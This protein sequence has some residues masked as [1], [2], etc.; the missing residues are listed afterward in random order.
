MTARLA[1]W[2]A[3]GAITHEDLFETVLLPLRNAP[4]P[5]RFVF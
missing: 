4:Q 3:P 2:T 1:R 5:A